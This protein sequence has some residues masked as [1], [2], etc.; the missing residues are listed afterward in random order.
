MKLVMCILWGGRSILTL[1]PAQQ[2]LQ[3]CQQVSS[4]C[5]RHPVSE[6]LVGL[7]LPCR[8]GEVKIAVCSTTDGSVVPV[9]ICFIESLE[10]CI[11]E[12]FICG[13][14]ARHGAEVSG[15]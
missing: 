3:A 9:A 8:A 15:D 10:F 13:H 7:T 2:P 11:A 4:V 1:Y 6:E 12:S 5:A 14:G